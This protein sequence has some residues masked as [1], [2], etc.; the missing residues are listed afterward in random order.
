MTLFPETYDPD[1]RDEVDNE[2][3]DIY[4]DQSVDREES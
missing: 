3:A 4:R 2:K 1:H